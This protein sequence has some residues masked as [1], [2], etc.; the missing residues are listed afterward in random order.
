MSDLSLVFGGDLAVAAHGD[1]AALSGSA[2][3]QQRVLRRLLTNAGDYIWQL[4]YGAGLPTMIG[5]PAQAAS[6]AGLVKSQ[7]FLEGAVAR[8]PAPAVTVETSGSIVSLTISY[9]D[10][11]DA[12]AQAVGITL[13]T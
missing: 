13:S 3:G 12:S 10:A 5:T 6:I 4:N 1:L 8:S 2:L 9:S 11:A 7:I